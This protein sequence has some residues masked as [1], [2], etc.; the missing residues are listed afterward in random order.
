[1]PSEGLRDIKVKVTYAPEKLY[2][3]DA[4]PDLPARELLRWVG[5]SEIR[6]KRVLAREIASVSP[7]LIILRRLTELLE[8]PVRQRR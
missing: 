3:V 1:M 7:R 2:P 4:V 6:A 8:I 5:R